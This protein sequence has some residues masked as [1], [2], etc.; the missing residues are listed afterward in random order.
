[1]IARLPQPGRASARRGNVPPM[2]IA[3]IASVVLI[4]A[5]AFTLTQL[6]S[7]SPAANAG[8]PLVLYCAAGLKPAVAG[9]VD[10]YSQEFGVPIEI[11]YGGSGTLLAQIEINPRGDLYLAADDSYIRL[12]REKALIA[13][14][15][16]I[17]TQ[18]PVIAVPQ[19]NPRD[20]QS[21]EDLLAPDVAF[22]LANPDAAAIGRITRDTLQ[23]EG[24]WD[25]FQQ[26]AK[27]FKPTVNE[28]ATDIKIG[29]VDAGIIWDCTA[30]QVDG[31]E[32][33]EVPELNAHPREIAIA[34]LTATEHPTNA[35]HFARYIA[36][37]DRG[38]KVLDSIG[39]GNLPRDLWTDRPQLLLYA[40]TMFNAVV[41]ETIQSFESRE[42]VEITRV[43]NGCGI[44]VA[45]MKAGGQPDAYFSCDDSFMDDVQDEF[46]NRVEVSQ[47]PL[48]IAVARDNP[49]GVEHLADFL[50]P[51][52][53]VGLAHPE[54]SA[55]GHLTGRLL[56]SQ[57]L[58]PDLVATDNWKLQAPQGDFL[59]NELRTGALDA[60]IVY[61][62]NT[63][64]A[65]DALHII[66]IDAPLAMARQPFAVARNSDNARTM[67]RL[68]DACRHPDSRARFEALGFTWLEEDSP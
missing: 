54:Y 38:G 13:E 39:Y 24:V 15:I 59:V 42:G 25:E 27:V 66:P 3:M 60:V 30:A 46:I 23:A 31:I 28:L 51:D 4:A 14:A 9:I 10:R 8:S 40:G 20:I 37:R 49:F 58:L 11:Q 62:S 53:R 64:P 19:G 44:L 2:A 55:L 67:Q 65:R 26:A 57:Q 7:R 16:P 41:E 50:K 63:A 35:L 29:A 36:A 45:Q 32:A 21:L 18:H 1:V 6:R 43:Y 48:V 68:I 61:L 33:V 47:N 17:A 5:L 22:G 34:V 12:G 52:L 56:E